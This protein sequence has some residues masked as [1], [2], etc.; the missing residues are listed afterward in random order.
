MRRCFTGY[1]GS[2]FV[3]KSLKTESHVHRRPREGR[4]DL[5]SIAPGL[6][7]FERQPGAYER[8]PDGVAAGLEVID[9]AT[10]PG[11]V[12]RAACNAAMVA[13]Q[14]HLRLAGFRLDAIA[15]LEVIDDEL[16]RIVEAVRNGRGAELSDSSRIGA[17][18]GAT[19]SERF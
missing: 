13:L 17:T 7:G 3:P 4:L 16:R 1:A 9:I 2:R 5:Q 19:G 15:E 12:R 14:E 10:V 18:N 8:V 11:A 6:G